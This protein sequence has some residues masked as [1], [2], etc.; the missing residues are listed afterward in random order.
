MA[1][2]RRAGLGAPAPGRAPGRT[3]FDVYRTVAKVRYSSYKGSIC[4]MNPGRSGGLTGR[5]P[6]PRSIQRTYLGLVLGNTLAASLIW[7]DQH[8]LPARRRPLQPGGLRGQRVL[9]GRDGAVRGAHRDR[10]RHGGPPDVVSARHADP[11]SVDAALRAA[12]G[13]GGAVLAVG[14]RVDAARPR[15]HLLLR[16][17]SRPGW[18]TR[19][20][21][22]ASRA[23]WR[24]CSGAGRW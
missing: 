8:D 10:R 18:S 23:S 6:R 20:R 22:R 11:H 13:A 19:S 1:L 5:C 16:A 12:L 2:Q 7:G 24:R 15:V 14:A 4:P 3:L 21:R 9:H 17:R